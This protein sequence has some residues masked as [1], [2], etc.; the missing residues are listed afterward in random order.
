M[1]LEAKLDV[2]RYDATDLTETYHVVLTTSNLFFLGKLS[3]ENG[4]RHSSLP[5][6]NL[7]NFKSFKA[8]S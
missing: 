1:N 6:S 2:A 7:Q 4:G 8:P 3:L 5:S